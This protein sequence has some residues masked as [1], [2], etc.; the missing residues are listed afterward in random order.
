MDNVLATARTRAESL[1]LTPKS[2]LLCTLD[3]TFPTGLIDAFLAPLS[4]GASLVQV[5]NPDPHRLPSHRTT[6]RTTMD[7]LK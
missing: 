2:R 3:W 5:S 4:A 1:G 7:L 6:E